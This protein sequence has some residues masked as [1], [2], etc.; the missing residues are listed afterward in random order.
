MRGR[1]PA[2][3]CSWSSNWVRAAS[4]RSGWVSGPST[5]P[6]DLF[7]C[8]SN[9]PYFHHCQSSS[10]CWRL[11]KNLLQKTQNNLCLE[12]HTLMSWILP[13][14]GPAKV[15]LTFFARPKTTSYQ[16]RI[17]LSGNNTTKTLDFCLLCLFVSKQGNDPLPVVASSVCCKASISRDGHAQLSRIDQDFFLTVLPL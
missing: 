8:V 3:L 10:F 13:S 17:V 5:L 15:R 1:F 4:E 9:G 2:S 14:M 16:C 7:F 12:K 11:E 6:S